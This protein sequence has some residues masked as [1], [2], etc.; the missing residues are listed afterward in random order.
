LHAILLGYFTHLINGFVCLH[1][2]DND[3]MFVFSDTFKE[4]VERD[5]LSVGHALMKQ[6]DIDL[7]KMH[8]TGGYLP[9]PKKGEDNSSG[10]KCSRATWSVVDSIVFSSS[11]WSIEDF[12]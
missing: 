2:I 10:E 12:T 9:D 11:A 6:S 3:N 1:R 8:F 4:E 7:P 5:L